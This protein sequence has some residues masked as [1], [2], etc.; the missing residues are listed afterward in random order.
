MVPC[1][2]KTRRGCNCGRNCSISVGLEKAISLP[3]QPNSTSG[4][5]YIPSDKIIGSEV[6]V[7]IYVTRGRL[8]SQSSKTINQAN[9]EIDLSGFSPGVYFAQIIDDDR[10]FISKIILQ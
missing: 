1:L 8:M 2:P 6:L 4:I 7:N 9:L 3:V 10:S 5:A